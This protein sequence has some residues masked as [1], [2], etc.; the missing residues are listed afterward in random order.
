[1]PTR[2]GVKGSAHTVCVVFKR[3]SPH[4]YVWAKQVMLTHLFFSF[5]VPFAR[6][7]VGEIDNAHT[8]RTSGLVPRGP[9]RPRDSHRASRSC[10]GPDPRPC[11]FNC[12]CHVAELRL[13][14]RTTTVAMVA[15]LQLPCM[16]CST[17]VAMFQNFRSCHPLT[18]GSCH[19]ALQKGMAKKHV[20][21]KERVAMCSQAR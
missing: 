2:V 7:R 5:P 12:S 14:C 20:R 19:V 11:S 13:P 4:A 6:V 18:L 1:M 21:V 17:A 3:I 16:I 15:Q 10:H 9:A 8:P